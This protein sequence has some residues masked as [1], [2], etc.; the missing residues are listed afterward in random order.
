MTSVYTQ[1]GYFKKKQYNLK[2][3]K[4]KKPKLTV[5]QMADSAGL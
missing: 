4:V 5:H 2:I 3:K 1:K